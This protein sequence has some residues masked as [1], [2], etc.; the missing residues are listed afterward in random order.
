MDMIVTMWTVLHIRLV[1]QADSR[2][3]LYRKLHQ[4]HHNC[5]GD[6]TVF[7]TAHA[8]TLDVGLCMSSFYVIFMFLSLY[9][10]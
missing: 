7:N 1:D 2:S 6:I 8:E 3:M 10:W 4:M 9:L 5:G